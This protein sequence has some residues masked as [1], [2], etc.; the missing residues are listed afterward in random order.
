MSKKSS[1]HQENP[2]EVLLPLTWT[3]VAQ[4]VCTVQRGGL[5]LGV[6]CQKL[7]D[8]WQVMAA[9]TPVSGKTLEEFFD[10]HAHKVVGVG[11]GSPAEALAVAEKFARAWQR[12]D[13]T[14][15]AP[16]CACPE[17]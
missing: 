14:T 3:T 13:E 8:G 10:N 7:G 4:F 17:L 15:G 12:G 1:V 5:R 16:K 2:A 9:T 6:V 11:Y